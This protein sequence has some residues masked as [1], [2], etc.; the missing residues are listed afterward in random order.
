MFRRSSCPYP[1]EPGAT[2]IEFLQRYL[3]DESGAT[4]IEYGL[5]ATFVSLASIVAY[6]NVANKLKTTFNDV[7]NNLAS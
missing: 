5:V 7:G 3:R 4:A 2:M 1:R 6:P